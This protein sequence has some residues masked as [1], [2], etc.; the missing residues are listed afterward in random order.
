MIIRNHAEQEN[1]ACNSYKDKRIFFSPVLTLS[2]TLMLW[3]ECFNNFY[4][5]LYFKGLIYHALSFNIDVH[6][7]ALEMN[8]KQRNE[9]VLVSTS[10]LYSIISL[11][12]IKECTV[13]VS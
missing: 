2:S 10:S 1:N 13:L 7:F 11:Y 5:L 4:K 8:G 6:F 9:G 3:K 12:I